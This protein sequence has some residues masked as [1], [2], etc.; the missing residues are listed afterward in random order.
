MKMEQPKSRREDSSEYRLRERIKELNCLYG[1]SKLADKHHSLRH[2]CQGAVSLISPAWQYPDITRARVVCDGDEFRSP[3]YRE[4]R[5]KQSA[6]IL[7]GGKEIGWIDVCYTKRMPIFDEGPFLKE[8]RALI[9]SVAEQLGI[10]YES[11]KAVDELR[12]SK[13][14]L[15]KQKNA[16]E[17]KN[18]ALRELIAQI[19]IEK[20][21]VETR[22]SSNI[23]DFVMP[24]IKKVRLKGV[25]DKY[26]Q[27]LQNNLRKVTDSFASN[28]TTE[29]FRLTPREMEICNMIRN[30]LTSKEISNLLSISMQT[31]EWHRKCIRRKIR[32]TNKNVNLTSH[33][34][35][36]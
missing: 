16:L 25:D 27:L 7:V 2:I 30:G 4:T 33:L 31:V 8:E 3:N 23:N 6:K 12:I 28:I 24:I 29:C 35:T 34:M 22:V 17:Q 10:I 15:I 19:E 21:N 20:R 11:K 13:E 26:I 5:W 18:V 1:L 9:E 36:V 32:I 14:N